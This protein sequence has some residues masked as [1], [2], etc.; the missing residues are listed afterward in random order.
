MVQPL[1]ALL[2]VAFSFL[3]APPADAP[4]SVEAAAALPLPDR[5][6]LDTAT[7]TDDS[8]WLIQSAPASAPAPLDLRRP[9]LVAAAAPETPHPA[10]GDRADLDDGGELPDLHLVRLTKDRGS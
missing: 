6:A 3:A 1:A 9:R 5:S 10:A 7:P 8:G 4:A 2:A